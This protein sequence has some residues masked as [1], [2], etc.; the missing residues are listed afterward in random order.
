MDSGPNCRRPG[1]TDSGQNCFKPNAPAAQLSAPGPGPPL[2]PGE[3]PEGCQGL[4]PFSAQ[5]QLSAPPRPK[6]KPS[7]PGSV[8]PHSPSLG[9]RVAGDGRGGV[10]T[11][12]RARWVAGR[13]RLCE[14]TDYLVELE[15]DIEYHKWQVHTNRMMGE[16]GLPIGYQGWSKD[17]ALQGV[18]SSMRSRTLIDVAWGSRP[19]KARTARGFFVDL[20][21]SVARSSSWGTRLC[22]RQNTICYSYEVDR[23]LCAREVMA[24]QG[25]PIRDLPLS[26]LPSASKLH[27]Y[28]GESMYLPSIATILIA[29]ICTDYV[30]WAYAASD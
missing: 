11:K 14:K 6:L 19:A 15:S 2:R 4:T 9:P 18:P 12:R 16:F 22:F 27:G 13:A 28:A 10:C 24:I 25:F 8:Q 5:P 20:S 21:Q 17:H 29:A 7:A 3:E 1:H 30:P 23:V 26:D